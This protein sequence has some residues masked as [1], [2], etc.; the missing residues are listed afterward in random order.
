MLVCVPQNRGLEL[1]LCIRCKISAIC[2]NLCNLCVNHKA[3][4]WKFTH[5]KLSILVFNFQTANFGQTWCKPRHLTKH[6]WC[7]LGAHRFRPGAAA[8]PLLPPPPLACCSWGGCRRTRPG[9]W[10][11]RRTA[12]CAR[13]KMCKPKTNQEQTRSKPASALLIWNPDEVYS[14]YIPCIY[15]VYSERRYIPGISQVYTM[16]IE[17]LFS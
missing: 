3:Q 14:R 11:F 16:D 7:K 4:T 8:T 15:H 5:C 13:V 1:T 2:V 9:C 12:K 6:N 17:I 10:S